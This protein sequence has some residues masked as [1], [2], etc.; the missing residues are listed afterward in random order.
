M[1]SYQFIANN[2]FEQRMPLQMIDHPIV[3]ILNVSY[4][5]KNSLNEI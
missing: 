3:Q 4:R 5:I 2:A 1:N